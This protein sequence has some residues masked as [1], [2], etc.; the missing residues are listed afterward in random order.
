M[1]VDEISSSRLNH[2][3]SVTKCVSQEEYLVWAVNHPSL[4]SDFLTLLTQVILL[5]LWW[6]WT[7]SSCFSSPFTQ[8]LINFDWLCL[9]NKLCNCKSWY[10]GEFRYVRI[11]LN[12]N[13]DSCSVALVIVDNYFS[14]SHS[15]HASWGCTQQSL[16]Q[17]HKLLPCLSGCLACTNIDS[18]ASLFNMSS[19]HA[20]VE[21][22]NVRGQ[23]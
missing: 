12:L 5:L 10:L 3:S 1:L 22:L 9:N 16:L 6:C 13:L 20:P 23:S 14:A 17:R 4:P 18:L 7:A 11:K 21:A 2:C 8:T 15:F 19:L